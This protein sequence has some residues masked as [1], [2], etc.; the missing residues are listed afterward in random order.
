[1][2]DREVGSSINDKGEGE[3]PMDRTEI[4]ELLKQIDEYQQ[5]IDDAENALD[6]AIENLEEAL[7]EA[8]EIEQENQ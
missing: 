8:Y 6:A 2:I 5:L 3:K 7:A 1:M 4:E